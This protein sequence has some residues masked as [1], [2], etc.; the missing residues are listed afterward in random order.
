VI[1]LATRHWPAGVGVA[2][3]LRHHWGHRRRRSRRVL[4]SES[5]HE[6][7]RSG[8]Q[9]TA[10]RHHLQQC[11]RRRGRYCSCCVR[12]TRSWLAPIRCRIAGA[13]QH[14]CGDSRS[15]LLGVQTGNSAEPVR[16]PSLGEENPTARRSSERARPA[17]QNCPERGFDL[18]DPR[19]RSRRKVIVGAR[20]KRG[21]APSDGG[22]RSPPVQ[23]GRW[24][25]RAPHQGER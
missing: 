23:R 18:G 17:S 8:L 6:P 1:A 20:D 3:A 22:T 13:K 25:P 12:L 7:R 11:R 10:L 5:D 15:L 16:R 2:R 19:A 14:S 4:L 21:A 9:I 24:P